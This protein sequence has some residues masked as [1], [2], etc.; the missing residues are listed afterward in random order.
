MTFACKHYDHDAECCRR[1]KCECIPGRPGC[2][3]DG[4]FELSED[5]KE[6]LK[7]LED[8]GKVRDRKE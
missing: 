3:L 7:S 2:M 4:Q 1:L 6:R 5:L 8:Q